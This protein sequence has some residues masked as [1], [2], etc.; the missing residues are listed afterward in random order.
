MVVLFGMVL[1]GCHNVDTPQ[2]EVGYV[3]QGAVF[4]SSRFVTTQVGPCSSGLGWLYAVKNVPITPV[5]YSE[6]FEGNSTVMSRDNL[7][8]QFAVHVTLQL[9]VTRT[10]EFVE[11]YGD[12]LQKVYDGFVKERVRTSA[13]DEIQMYDALAVKDNIGAIGS[14]VDVTVHKVTDGTPLKVISVVVGNIQY[15]DTVKNAVA[16]KLAS[17]QLLEQ[18]ATEVAIA[19]REAQKRVVEAKG[20]AEAMNIVQQKLTPLY[21]QHEAIEAQK[22][23]VNSPNHTVLYVPVG[24][25]GVPLV[26]QPPGDS[27]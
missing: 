11:K 4:G 16:A 13:R 2:G 25:M 7:P 18:K 21:L 12:D 1:A 23:Q 20:I 10:Q 19:E 6:S 15:P 14:K 17:T 5:T 8:I 27:R 24:N 22:L 3:T 26:Q 9:D